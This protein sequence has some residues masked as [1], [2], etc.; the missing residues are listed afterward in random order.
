M[1]QHR[2]APSC[3]LVGALAQKLGRGGL[4]PDCA[5]IQDWGPLDPAK[6]EISLKGSPFWRGA[7]AR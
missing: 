6:A 4:M 1:A 3:A 5:E 2:R 7:Q